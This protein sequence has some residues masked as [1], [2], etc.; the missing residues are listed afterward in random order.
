[1]KIKILPELPEHDTADLRVTISLTQQLSKDPFGLFALM[2]SGIWNDFSLLE[3]KVE[4]WSEL[5]HRLLI[6]FSVV[7]HHYK[8]IQSLEQH[9]PLILYTRSTVDSLLTNVVSQS[10]PDEAAGLSEVLHQ[11]FKK[12]LFPSFTFF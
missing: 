7:C 6:F 8:D 10:F 11:V 12:K 3:G 4:W 9:D 2:I 1:M 5:N